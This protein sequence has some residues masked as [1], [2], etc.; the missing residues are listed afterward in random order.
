[1]ILIFNFLN[2]K[3]QKGAKSRL[4]VLDDLEEKKKCGRVRRE[5][6]RVQ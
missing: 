1:M 3:E 6:K 4:G 5:E 2:F